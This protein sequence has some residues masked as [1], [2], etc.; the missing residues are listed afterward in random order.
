[1]IDDVLDYVSDSK[2]LGKSS[3]ADL[4]EGNITGPVLFSLHENI[5]P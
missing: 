2:S 5:L 4:K 1:L 3:F